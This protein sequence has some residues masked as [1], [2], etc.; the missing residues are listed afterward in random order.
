MATGTAALPRPLFSIR[1]PAV[2]VTCWAALI[3]VGHALGARLVDAD[4][5]V[6]IGAPPLVGRYEAALSA[7]S[8]PAVL[9][10]GA[11]LRWA[12]RLA[13]TLAW[14]RLLLLTWLGAG[15]WA[16]LLALADGPHAIVAPLQSRY[17]Y[18]AAVG[19]VGNPLDFLSSFTAALP[20]YPTH[21]KGH[22]PGLVLLFWTFAQA[23]LGG[24]TVAAVLVIAVGALAAPAVLITVRAIGDDA[25]ARAAA[26]FV[27]LAPAAVWVATSGDALFMGVA[28]CGVAALAVRR[29]LLGGVLL[30]C[31]L[32]LT[33]GAAPL[34][35]VALTAAWLAAG[36]D[37]PRLLLAAA[38]G[39]A[40]VLG[41]V[42]AAGFWWPD[43][44]HATRELYAAGVASRRPY[45]DFLLIAPAA[46]ALAVGPA[47]AAGLARVRGDV[48]VVVAG[49]VL[50]VAAADLS[51]LSRG[52]N[53]RIWLLFTPWLLCAAAALPRPR[54]WLAA[55]LA[56]G[57]TLQ[58]V[59]R[60]P[61]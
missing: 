30:G 8:V 3:W 36:R 42:A 48:G 1:A 17:E 16:V 7:W 56:L 14:R 12:P 28:A 54:A 9:F 23:G 37:A 43:G 26:P 13:G 2:A 55:Q 31:A 40:A 32:M 25:Q 4:P 53:E 15:A 20:G 60:S 18:L 5:L 58:L 10:A 35:L 39:V 50:A 21:V 33:Y 45:V 34:G 6:H 11:A 51:G 47:A 19:R 59:V 24:A 57:L 49:A 52:E 41:T 29:G 27:A 61:W 46:L 22:P 38:L 44:L